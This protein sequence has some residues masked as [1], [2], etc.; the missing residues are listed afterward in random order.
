MRVLVVAIIIVLIFLNSWGQSK[1]L[2][3]RI[4]SCNIKIDGKIDEQEWKESVIANDFV[5]YEPYNGNKPSENTT[6][7]IKIDD[8]NLYIAAKCYYLQTPQYKVITQRDEFGQAD[9]FGFYIDTYNS[10]TN[11]YGFFV[12]T[13]G[14]Q[15]DFKIENEQKNFSWDAIWYSAVKNYDSVISIEIKIPFYSIRIPNKDVQT[16]GINFFRYLQHYREMSSWN[17]ID[18]SKSGELHQ[19]GKLY[20]QDKINAPKY[21]A[22]IPYA[23]SYNLNNNKSKKVYNNFGFGADI[24]YNLNESF[25]L[26]M[27]LIPDFSDVSTDAQV[28]NLSP[29]EIYYSEKRYFFTEGTEIFNKGNI[30]YSRRIGKTPTK[31]NQI[32][33]LLNKNQV[34]IENPYY[35]QII[36]ATKISGRTGKGMGLGLLNAITGNTFATVLDTINQTYSKILT[37][38]WANYNIAVIDIPLKNSSYLSLTNTN[39]YN[40]GNNYIAN[41]SALESTIKNKKKSHQLFL[42]N[43][44]SNIIKDKKNTPG[45]YHEMKFQKISGQIRYY[46]NYSIINDTYNPNDLGYLKENNL[47]KFQIGGNYNIYKPKGI[48]L[49]QFNNISI[50]HQRLFSKFKYQST[51]VYINTSGKL[52]DHTSIGANIS[53]SLDSIYDYKEPR[54]EDRFYLKE[55][56]RSMRLWISTNY[57]RPLAYDLSLTS[58]FTGIPT[59]KN[60]KRRQLGYSLTNSFRIRFSDNVL[61]IYR[62]DYRLDFNN[63]GFIGKTANNDTV[64][65]GKRNINYITNTVEAYVNLSK[66]VSL[67][68]VIRHYWSKILYTEFYQLAPSGVLYPLNEPY[69]YIKNPNINFNILNVDLNYTWNIKPGTFLNLSY[70]KQITS[71]T[72]KIITDYYENFY[73]FYLESPHLNSIT[74]KLVVYFNVKI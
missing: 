2:D 31:Y 50:V 53:F 56:E 33:R 66:D 71:T 68:L 4:T 7:F 39:Y 40:P 55:P 23:S 21:L 11:A 73:Q 1:F 25:T 35:T 13:Q 36:N 19:I 28:L 69:K 17:Y 27:M 65:F 41:V 16:W 70:R 44:F 9:Y 42:Y 43:S 20:L 24:K 61:T 12:T 14:V 29:Y 3:L 46:F 52:K 18:N 57:A 72:N 62:N 8:K 15:I 34:I 37:E 47:I 64:F 38:T 10:G 22:L 59:R 32:E 30:F 49:N 51:I 26:D 45:F 54:A 5:Q 48:F 67:S 60:Y 74:L 6:L 58:Y 63:L